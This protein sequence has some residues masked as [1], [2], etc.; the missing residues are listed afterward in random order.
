MP[1][2]KQTARET[3]AMLLEDIACGKAKL[4]GHENEKPQALNGKVLDL[5]SALDDSLVIGEVL[6]FGDRGKAEVLGVEKEGS[7]AYYQIRLTYSP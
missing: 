3:V 1:T 4:P 6:P 7:S 2:S 5:R